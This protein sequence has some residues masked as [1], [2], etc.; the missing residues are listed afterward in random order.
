MSITIKQINIKAN[1][2][3]AKEREAKKIRLLTKV[4]VIL[5]RY[6]FNNTILCRFVLLFPLHFIYLITHYEA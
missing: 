5:S 3:K 1:Q 6:Y 2:R 4:K